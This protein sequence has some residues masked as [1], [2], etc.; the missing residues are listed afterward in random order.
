MGNYAMN[1]NTSLK[2]ALS[3][4][5]R[6]LVTQL[7]TMAVVTLSV[8][9]FTFFYFIYF[10]L[11]HFV[12]RFGTE[13]GL[14]VFLKQDVAAT[15]IPEIYQRL[16]RLSGVDSVNYI[17][18]EEAM[19]RLETYL[20]DEKDVLEGVDPNF[21]PPS[22]E[23]QINKAFQNLDMIRTMGKQIEKWPEVFRVKYGQEW[24]ARLKAFTKTARVV[25]WISAVFLLLTAAFVVSNTIR[26]AFYARQEEIEILRLV[27]ATRAFIQTPFLIQ[28]L[29]QGLLGASL[30]VGVVFSCYLYLARLVA[31][32]GFL[33]GVG[34][35]FLPWPH[36]ALII[37]LSGAVCTVWTAFV[38]RRSLSL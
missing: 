27:G 20:N 17:S 5:K 36:V 25:V 38:M 7:M 13:L 28:A 33:R 15:Q 31:Q 1:L 12:Q 6:H 3:D 30:A 11:D 21:L 26:L 37:I 9:I 18:R 32:S 16:V 2:R 19:K 14:V 10:N 29:L 22:F 8:L 24:M 23:L 34:L 4:L 35:Y